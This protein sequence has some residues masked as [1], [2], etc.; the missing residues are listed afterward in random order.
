MGLESLPVEAQTMTS[1]PA[2]AP[3]N[4]QARSLSRDSILVKW[5]PCETPNGLITGYKVYYT[6]DVVTTPLRQWKQHDAKADEFMTTIY[7]LEPDSRYF[8]K[9]VAQN[10]EGD[11]P[12]SQLVTVA[13]RQGSEL[14]FR[15]I[16][17]MLFH[18]SPRPAS[19]VE[20]E[21]SRLSQNATDMGQTP[22][23]FACRRLHRPIQYHRRRERADTDIAAREARRHW[24]AS[25][26]V[27]L[28]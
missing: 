27:L 21:S 18:S 3:V 5:G 15:V 13:T 2:T 19:N 8:V 20:S 25:R 26:Q 6:N 12:S 16:F 1:K 22:L 4:P 14:F 17:S 9:I 23:L 28:F 7:G 11:S 24:A 10:S